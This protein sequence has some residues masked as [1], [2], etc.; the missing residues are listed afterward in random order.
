MLTDKRVGVPYDPIDDDP[1]TNPDIVRSR[2]GNWGL[3]G[4]YREEAF[5]TSHMLVL[6]AKSFASCVTLT[7]DWQDHFWD[8]C[9]RQA[10]NSLIYIN[11]DA[12]TVKP[13]PEDVL[14][15]NYFEDAPS[16]RQLHTLH[17][18]SPQACSAL[19]HLVG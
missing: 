15:K 17:T 2:D 14:R 13:A 3:E 8:W 9:I 19:G 1:S 6:R 4:A 7:Y 11:Q 10:D 12:E 18:L 5:I 16:N